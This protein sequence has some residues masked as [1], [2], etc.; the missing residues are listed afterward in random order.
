M[1]HPIGWIETFDHWSCLK[2]VRCIL[3]SSQTNITNGI[4]YLLRSELINVLHKHIYTTEKEKWLNSSSF[5]IQISIFISFEPIV[6]FASNECAFGWISSH[7]CAIVCACAC[8]C[9]WHNQPLRINFSSMPFLRFQFRIQF[10]LCMDFGFCF[11]TFSHV[12]YVNISNRFPKNY[13][14][15]FYYLLKFIQSPSLSSSFR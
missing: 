10:I 14:P 12:N 2:I 1:W 6:V 4:K 15:T 11:P 5:R 7:R 8:L 13:E 9:V 3:F